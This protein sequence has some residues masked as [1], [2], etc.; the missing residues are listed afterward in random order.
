M[1]R[2]RRIDGDQDLAAQPVK[3]KPL[4]QIL[5]GI[6]F[7]IDQRFPRC[8]WPDEEVEQRLALR[9]QQ[10]GIDGERAGY[11]IRN[12]TLE[13]GEDI[14]FGVFARQTDHGAM[15]ETSSGHA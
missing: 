7:A 9:R 12:Q 8:T 11:V 6:R 1:Y 10:S 14:L 3:R 2:Y 13:E 4:G 5:R 15:L